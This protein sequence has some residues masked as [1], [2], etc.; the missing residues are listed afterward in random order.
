MVQIVV[1][2]IVEELFEDS[3][4]GGYL[5]IDTLNRVVLITDCVIVAMAIWLLAA[6]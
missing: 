5:W 3:D 6:F 1:I 4:F 2:P